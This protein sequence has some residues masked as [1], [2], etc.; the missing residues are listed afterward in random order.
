MDLG[1]T[2]VILVSVM[3]SVVLLLVCLGVKVV[4]SEVDSDT[5]SKYTRRLLQIVGPGAQRQLTIQ[6][7]LAL[8]LTKRVLTDTFVGTV[9]SLLHLLDG[10][11]GVEPVPLHLLLSVM[12]LRPQDH[13]LSEHPV[14]DGLVDE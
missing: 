4:A 14:G 5:I 8:S 12:A 11:P 13:D 2:G 3:W 9:V 10:E 7:D 1:H 6:P